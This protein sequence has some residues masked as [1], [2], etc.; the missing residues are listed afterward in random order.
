MI[1][2]HTCSRADS[3]EIKTLVKRTFSDSESA[4]KGKLIGN[5]AF[6]LLTQTPEQDVFGFIAKQ[7]DAIVGCVIFS[8]LFLA[9]GIQAF[10]LA[11]AAVATEFQRQ[12][13]GQQLIRFGL[14]QLKQNGIELALT[15]GDPN[16][17]SKVG[18][19]PISEQQNPAPLKLTYP[20]GWPAQSLTDQPIP[21][22]KQKPSC[23]SALAKPEYW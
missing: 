15:Y 9:D 21:H 17:Y 16:Y 6:E 7:N 20:H 2:L 23:V 22:L 1:Q 13:I 12:G 18:F 4:E 10:I 11:P 19:Q 8:R 5:L 14:Q 3:P